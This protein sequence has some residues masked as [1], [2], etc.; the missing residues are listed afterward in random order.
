[1]IAIMQLQACWTGVR[2]SCCCRFHARGLLPPIAC[3][4]SISQ[5]LIPAALSAASGALA[6]ALLA[7]ATSDADRQAALLSDLLPV[8]CDKVLSAKERGSPAALACWGALAAAA[9]EEQVT[10]TLLPT[11]VRMTKRNPEPALA[12]AA[13]M[14]AALRCAWVG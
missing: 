4:L 10:A 1:M 7:S 9:S 13:P 8:Y 6:R 14:L 3:R 12:A 2:A 5:P 11:V